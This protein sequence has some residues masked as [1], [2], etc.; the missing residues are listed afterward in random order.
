MVLMKRFFRMGQRYR[1]EHLEAM[2]AQIQLSRDFIDNEI[3]QLFPNHSNWFHV[4]HHGIFYHFYRAHAENLRPPEFIDI[5]V[6]V[7]IIRDELFEIEVLGQ[8]NLVQFTI[9]N[10]EIAARVQVFNRI[11]ELENIPSTV[12]IYKH[13]HHFG[14]RHPQF[15][16]V[17]IVLE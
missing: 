3:T 4:S 2:A 8:D 14:Q 10:G 9:P 6:S 12:R 1:G 13:W 17:L 15:A 5:D 7:R 16:N 11:I